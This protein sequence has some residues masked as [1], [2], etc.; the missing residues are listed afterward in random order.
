MTKEHPHIVDLRKITTSS[1]ISIDKEESGFEIDQAKPS[2]PAKIEWTTSEFKKY[3]RK[4][5]WFI[6]PALTALILIII[7]ILLKNF[8]FAI[9][10]IFAALAVYIYAQKEP[11]KIKF[12]ISGEGIQIEQT[13][14]KYEDLKSF[15]IFYEPPEVKELSIRSKKMFMPYIKL[16]LGD[17]NPAKIRKLLLRFLP[18][19]KHPESIIDEWTRRIKF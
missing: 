17:Q 2:I 18:E 5:N 11:R 12:S 13:I 9:L 6:L 8:L 7:A 16:P 14:Y 3:K 19:K 15:W 4:K 10:I 1:P